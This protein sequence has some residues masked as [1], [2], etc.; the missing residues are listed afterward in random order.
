MGQP[1][2]WPQKSLKEKEQK[3]KKQRVE[4]KARQDNCAGSG[5]QKGLLE[6][7]EEAA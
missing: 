4:E 5:Q 2:L 6:V 1:C 7:L 3:G